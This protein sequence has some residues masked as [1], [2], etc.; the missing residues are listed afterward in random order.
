LE[1]EPVRVR[2]EPQRNVIDELKNYQNTNKILSFK[3][4]I[5]NEVKR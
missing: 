3:T 1:R 5:K 4:E 2:E